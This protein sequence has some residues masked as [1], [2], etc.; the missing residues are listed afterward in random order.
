MNDVP[1]VLCIETK[2]GR[3]KLIV[4]CRV[5]FFDHDL[6][7]FLRICF[8]IIIIPRTIRSCAAT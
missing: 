4:P 1:L 2:S 3:L 8:S 6:S 7:R 5:P